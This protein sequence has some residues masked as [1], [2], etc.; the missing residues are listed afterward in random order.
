MLS[1]STGPEYAAFGS[2]CSGNFRSILNWFI[3][4]IESEVQGFRTCKTDHVTT[5]VS[6]SNR[7]TFLGY[8]VDVC[9]K[10]FMW[11]YIDCILSLD[12]GLLQRKA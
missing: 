10:R 5:A 6:D 2:H 9:G 11:A 8:P 12:R 4:N 1:V 7:G 3:P